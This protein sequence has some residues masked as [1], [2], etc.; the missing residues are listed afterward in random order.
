[1]YEKMIAWYFDAL[2]LSGI[3]LQKQKKREGKSEKNPNN[4]RARSTGS[5]TRKGTATSVGEGG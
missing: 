4:W 2:Q 5:R 3:H 1:V